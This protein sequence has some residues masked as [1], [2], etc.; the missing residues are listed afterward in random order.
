M[1]FHEQPDGFW[2]APSKEYQVYHKN[3]VIGWGFSP[4]EAKR[5]ARMMKH[6]DFEIAHSRLGVSGLFRTDS[7]R[8]KNPASVARHNKYK[9]TGSHKG[10][11]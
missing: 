5:K 9:R 1:K 2:K 6:T 4:S 3:K 11:R 7:R 8:T 10:R